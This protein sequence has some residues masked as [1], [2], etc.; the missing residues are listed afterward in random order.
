M[1][2]SDLKRA[3][4]A[5]IVK[6]PEAHPPAEELLACHRGELPPEVLLRVRD[7]LALCR[8]CTAVLLDLANMEREEDAE[9]DTAW[10][11]LQARR[12]A[13]PPAELHTLPP[14]TKRFALRLPRTWLSLQTWKLAAALDLIVLCLGFGAGWLLASR[15]QEANLTQPVLSVPTAELLPLAFLRRGA[16]TPVRIPAEAEVFTLTLVTAELPPPTGCDLQV[17][18]ADG[19]PVWR[20]SGLRADAEGRFSL[21]LPG[22]FLPAGRY[23]LQVIAPEGSGRQVLDRYD[24][25]LSYEHA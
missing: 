9:L 23:Q 22:G 3:L 17:L 24:L 1:A 5:T 6:P 8:P 10:R 18:D 4:E 12:Q 19:N 11:A 2:K 21:L 25:E 15:P 20:G 16:A 13:A 14:A 7:H